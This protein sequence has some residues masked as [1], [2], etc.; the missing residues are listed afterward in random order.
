MNEQGNDV[1]VPMPGDAVRLSG[2]WCGL[3][4][5]KIGVLGGVVGHPTDDYSI[6]FNASTFR[7]SRCSSKGV[8]I[9]SCSGGPATIWTPASE[10]KPTDEKVTIRCWH[11]RKNF[12]GAHRGVSYLVEVPVW[13]WAGYEAE[14]QQYRRE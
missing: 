14:S 3:E 9:V 4:A 1:R 12:P 10:L 13:E 11:W 7:G 6:T 2:T 8:H 5:G